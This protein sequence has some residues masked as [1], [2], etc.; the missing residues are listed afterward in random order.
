MSE[1]RPQAHA[2]P[3]FAKLN[4]PAAPPAEV[5]R[6]KLSDAARQSQL[7]QLILV[8]APAGFG[9]TTTMAQIRSRMEDNGVVTSWLTL[10]HS[11]ND[12][13]RFLQGLAAAIGKVTQ[14]N[15]YRDTAAVAHSRGGSEL[16]L[17]DCL[18]AHTAPFA[19][20]L[21]DFQYIHEPAVLGVLQQIIYHL[22]RGGQIVVGSRSVPDLDLGRLRARGQLL[23]IDSDLLRFSLSETTEFFNERRGLPLQPEDLF[24]LQSKTEGWAA[25]LWLASIA[26]ERR[27]DRS[28]FITRFSGTDQSISEYLANDVVGSQ[29]QLVRDFLLHTSILRHLNASLCNAVTERR[30]GALMLKQIGM[31]NLFLQPIESEEGT[32]RY[33]S[34]FASFLLGEL[35]RESPEQIPQLHR[36]ASFWYESQ[37]REVPAI[38]HALGARDYEHALRLLSLHADD[39]LRQ[40]RMRLLQRWISSV[41]DGVLQRYPLLQTT[42][43]W[44]LCFTRGPWEAMELLER[45]EC[46]KTDDPDVSAH[47]LALRPVMLAMMDR[48]EEAAELGRE[49]LLHLPPGNSFPN[50]VMTNAVAYVLSVMGQ[51]DEAR[52][53]L[54]AARRTQ[55]ERASAFNLM[56]SESVEGIID[57]H[58]GRL[59]QAT[60]RFRIGVN[61]KGTSSRCNAWAGILFAGVLYEANEWE[62]AE[63]LLHIYLPSA[64]DVGLV[65]HM[66]IGH[67]MLSR[68]AFHRGDVDRA[69]QALTELE[70]LGHRR[71][72]PRLV[73]TAKLERSMVL[74]LQGYAQASKKELDRANEGEIWKWVRGRRLLANDSH[75]LELCQ[76]R[77][78]ILAGNAA[79]ILPALEQEIAVSMASARHR[80]ALKLRVLH[81]LALCRTGKRAAAVAQMGHV[82][83]AACAE[84]FM[85]LVLD[86]GAH[87]AALVR[88]YAALMR[89]QGSGP[90]DPIFAEYLQRLLQCVGPE[91]LEAEPPAPASNEAPLEPLTRKESSI[92]QLVAEGYSNSAMAEKLFVSDSTVRTH[93]RNINTKLGANNRTQAVALA[94]RSALIR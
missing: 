47:V 60:A 14:D 3:L 33:H 39:L 71:H 59:R 82:L 8:R 34:L 78:E 5:Q 76:F 72:L 74:L 28:E 35:A 83:H 69:W 58:E 49:Q 37:G 57:L 67:I 65:D 2:P 44:S 94:R 26:L 87:V 42:Y 18:L 62:Q 79:Q 75:Y 85:R 31:A 20:F 11:D 51:Y 24:R 64:E 50:A 30:D 4:P 12:P 84:G 23:E 63:R 19:L 66:I 38:D 41:P 48:Y 68:I 13:P 90:S 86:E 32:Y 93:L 70:Y 52:K 73:G 92:L 45:M 91:M 56:Y 81:S 40:G 43:L 88:Q 54:D 89:E 36:R 1:T 7:T 55:G 53:L 46:R 15:F 6:T 77:W 61:T 9:K 17:V 29:P 27:E 10:D 25:A 16:S 22:P 21:D 80:R